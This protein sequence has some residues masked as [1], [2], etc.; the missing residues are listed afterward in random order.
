MKA[1]NV[2]RKG[3]HQSVVAEEISFLKSPAIIKQTKGNNKMKI[4]MNQLKKIIKEEV[5]GYGDEPSEVTD[6]GTMVWLSLDGQLSRSGGPAMVSPNG[7]KKWYYDG[8]LHRIGGPAIDLANGYKAWWEYDTLHRTD[9]PAREYPDGSVEWWLES[10]RYDT[11]EEW[12]AAKEEQGLAESK[13]GNNKMK[14]TMNQ[15]KRMIKEEVEKE[16]AP[17]ESKKA[18]IV[19]YFPYGDNDCYLHSV[20]TNKASAQ[21]A[22]KKLIEDGKGDFE[23]IAFFVREVLLDPANI[24]LDQLKQI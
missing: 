12:L 23:K 1:V 16:V 14:I 5:E 2:N 7:D 13:K 3:N 24:S 22:Y 18:W 15:L 17:T 20:H 8:M 19:G 6:D 4:T 9:G 10:E 21:K 11:E